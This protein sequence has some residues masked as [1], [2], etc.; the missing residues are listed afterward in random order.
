MG[1]PERSLLNQQAGSSGAFHPYHEFSGKKIPSIP[2]GRIRSSGAGKNRTVCEGFGDGFVPGWG[3]LRGL[4]RPE[5]DPEKIPG[6]RGGFILKNTTT[7]TPRG[8]ENPISPSTL[9]RRHLSAAQTSSDSH[10]PAYSLLLGN[11]PLQFPACREYSLTIPGFSPVPPSQHHKPIT[12]PPWP[13]CR[14]SRSRGQ[15]PL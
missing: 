13:R 4:S 3:T 11:I 2:D 1:P 12:D 9:W 5:F 14:R 6:E 15:N 7:A 10:C 8:M